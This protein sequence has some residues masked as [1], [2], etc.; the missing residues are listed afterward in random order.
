MN[1]SSKK[2]FVLLY[3]LLIISVTLVLV[4]S[5]VD[6]SLNELRFS[7]DELRS[8]TAFY[9]ADSAI[10]CARFW[11]NATNAI[12]PYSAFDTRNAVT[13][14]PCGFGDSFTAGQGSAEAFC[15][16]SGGAPSS[17]TYSTAQLNQFNSGSNA[18]CADL[19]VTVTPGPLGLCDI[20]FVA[21]GKNDCRPGALN[22]VERTRWETWG[23]L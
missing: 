16:Y 3:T 14:Y 13:T 20:F 17:V 18:P 1:F 11:Q 6:S 21:K 2:G 7:G 5:I 23:V 9:A 10:E 15:A 4:L 22:V 12:G 8:M 19:S